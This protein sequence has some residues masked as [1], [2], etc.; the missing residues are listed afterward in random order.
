M[1]KKQ[2]AQ[3]RKQRSRKELGTDATPQGASFDTEAGRAAQGRRSD[4]GAPDQQRSEEAIE[5]AMGGASDGQSGG[6][7]G[8]GIP[9][10]DS[11]MRQEDDRFTRGDVKEDRKKIFKKP[12]EKKPDKP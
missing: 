7:G 10:P 11:A 6:G 3:Q 8:A 4:I 12:Q 2:K 5:S 1:D 9:D